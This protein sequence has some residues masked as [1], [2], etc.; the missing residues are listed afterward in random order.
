MGVAVCDNC[1]EELADEARFCARCGTPVGVASG[2]AG[3][4]A[5]APENVGKTCPYCRFPLKV[6]AP[7]TVCPACEAV[8]H[9]ECWADNGGCAMVGCSGGPRETPASPE[10]EA[11]PT[12][13]RPTQARPLA[14]PS[15]PGTPGQRRGNSWIVVLAVA[16]LGTVIAVITALALGVL[17]GPSTRVLTESRTLTERVRSPSASPAEGTTSGETTP[18]REGGETGESPAEPGLEKY[19]GS[20]V[21]ASIP[22]GW[23][24]GEREVSK[25]Q[26]VEST[27]HEDGDTGTYLL[28]DKHVPPDPPSLEAAAQPVRAQLERE[29]GYH[30]VSWGEGDLE[31]RSSWEWVFEVPGSERVDYFFNTCNGPAAVLGS[32]APDRFQ[33]LRATFRAV[34]ASVRTPCE[35]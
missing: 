12:L 18:S 10:R 15:P 29:S 8:H 3:G 30:E 14:P 33:Q 28:I 6:G 31:G 1:R 20:A 27:W 26:E 19:T 2:E 24:Q 17:D 13:V 22:S 4:L 16:S 11:P 35:G 23:V 7:T 9:A 25:P 32:S 21:T 34:A 5:S